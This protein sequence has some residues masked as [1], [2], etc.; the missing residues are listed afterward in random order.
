MAY[1]RLSSR[2]ACPSRRLTVTLASSPPPRSASMSAPVTHQSW[3]RGA[4]VATLSIR[5]ATS[6]SALRPRSS[7]SPRMNP[8][9][10]AWN[11]GRRRRA[12]CATVNCRSRR[13]GLARGR[14]LLG[15]EVER[16]S[17]PSDRSGAPRTARR[18]LSSGSS[19]S[20]RSR[21]P[22][23]TRS[24]YVGS[25]TLERI[26]ASRPSTYWRASV[27]LPAIQREVCSISSARS[28]APYTSTTRSTPRAE[29]MSSAA[30]RD[31]L[32][33]RG[34]L[35]RRLERDAHFVQRRGELAR[36]EMQCL[37]VDRG[38]AG[39]GQDS[40]SPRRSQRAASPRPRQRRAP[41]RA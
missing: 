28:A 6:P 2:S 29:R 7:P 8:S 9:R 25:C 39:H 26:S 32:L 34:R 3:Y 24:R 20:A 37:L 16:S 11:F 31:R 36:D 13:A 33:V 15:A 40:I 4:E 5:F 17:V 27:S 41:A 18:S 38:K 30:L 14:G 12:H 1:R 21:P 19:T 23:S 35:G 10:P 22:P